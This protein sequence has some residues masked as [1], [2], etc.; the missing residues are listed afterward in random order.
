L[1]LRNKPV[2]LDINIFIFNRAP[3]SLDKN[4]VED[5]AAAIHADGNTLF[6]ENVCKANA[7]ELSAL[8]CVKYFGLAIF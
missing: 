4:I 2:F 1:G 3:E 6:F 7:G 5:L 8:I